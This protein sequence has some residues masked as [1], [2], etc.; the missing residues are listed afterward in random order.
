M[1]AEDEAGDK[2][3]DVG[4]RPTLMGEPVEVINAIAERLG[5]NVNNEE[6]AKN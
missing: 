1:R 6:I 3:F 4:D 5:A 2:V